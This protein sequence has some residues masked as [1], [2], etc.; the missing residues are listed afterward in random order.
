VPE[1]RSLGQENET[2]S[3]RQAVARNL[4]NISKIVSLDYF[5]KSILPLYNNL[6]ADKD[7][8]VRKT[9]ADII[10]EIASVSPVETKS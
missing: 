4:L 9:C 3:V 7:E 8:K 10:A 1:I 6:S 5:S 2:A